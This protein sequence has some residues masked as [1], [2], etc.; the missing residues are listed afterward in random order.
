MDTLAVVEGEV[1]EP[2][3]AR[4]TAQIVLFDAPPI[5]GSN[6]GEGMNVAQ[7]L[8][9]T[10]RRS[11]HTWRNYLGDYRDFFCTFLGGEVTPKGFPAP[12]CVTNFLKLPRREIILLSNRYRAS[13]LDRQL[14]EASI[15]RRFAALKKLIK[16]AH[17][18]EWCEF[19]GRD[20]VDVER[21]ESYRDTAGIDPETT[22]LILPL[23]AQKYGKGSV[24]ALRDEALIRLMATNGLRRSSIC[25]CDV[26]DFI[27][28]ERR[29]AI[30][31][32]GKGTQKKSVRLGAVTADSI[33]AYLLANGHKDDK[34]PLFRNL[35]RD[36]AINGERLRENGL[37]KIVKVYGKM[38]ERPEIRP[39]LFRHGA[40]T[41]LAK[42][43][44]GNLVEVQEFSGHAK[45][46]TVRIY[47]RNSEDTQGRMTDLMEDLI[48][49]KVK[50]KRRK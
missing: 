21:V 11:P 40:I 47:V 49:G 32:K 4:S 30:L 33:A 12:E 36:P 17:K 7:E 5:K 10:M 13:L 24:H 20:L 50:P 2:L 25:R 14:S 41:A 19:D 27:Y 34:G 48:S 29:L 45:I 31:R 39:H 16:F 44:N 3:L 23:P 18:M 35:H 46:E 38:I 43:T 9:D 6:G 15:A 28:S 37:W 1:V 22:K 8:L 42:A 26:G